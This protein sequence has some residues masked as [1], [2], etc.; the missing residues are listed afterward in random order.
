MILT[1]EY[2]QDTESPLAD[3]D[4]EMYSFNSRHSNFKHPTSFFP[5][6]LGLLRKLEVGTAFVLSCYMH[7]NACWSLQGEGPQCPWDTAQ[8]AG[9]LMYRG[10]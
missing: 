10:S 1:I 6:D 2:D 4:W 9:L 7:G 3:S 5:P 8:T